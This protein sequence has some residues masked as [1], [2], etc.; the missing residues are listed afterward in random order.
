MITCLQFTKSLV[1]FNFWDAQ[2][3]CTSST[4]LGK[5]FVDPKLSYISDSTLKCTLIALFLAQTKK[6]KEYEKNKLSSRL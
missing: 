2:K 4:I 1:I 6:K 3:C 5:T